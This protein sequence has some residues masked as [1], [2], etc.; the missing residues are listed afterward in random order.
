MNV[1]RVEDTR[2]AEGSRSGMG[3]LQ[4]TAGAGMRG[5][6]DRRAGGRGTPSA[7]EWGHSSRETLVSSLEQ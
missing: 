7:I 4:A 6:G 2:R 3:K 1:L 5:T